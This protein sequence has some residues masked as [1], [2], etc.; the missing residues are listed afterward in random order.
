MLQVVLLQIIYSLAVVLGKN[1][2]TI[3]QHNSGQLLQLSTA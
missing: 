1:N 3:T 2:R